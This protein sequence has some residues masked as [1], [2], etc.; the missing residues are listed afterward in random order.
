MAASIPNLR[1]LL[2][3]FKSAKKTKAKQYSVYDGTHRKNTPR[4]NV[5]VVSANRSG[6]GT[7]T[8]ELTHKSHVTGDDRSDRS[9]LGV[10]YNANMSATPMKILQTQE[11]A[12]EYHPR[13]DERLKRFTKRPDL[14]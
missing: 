5:V 11:V 9:I 1:M 3:G 2:F 12:V 14:G 10:S 7:D 8:M 4:G 6:Q 13:E